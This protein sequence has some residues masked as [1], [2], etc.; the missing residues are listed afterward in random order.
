MNLITSKV[1]KEFNG[2]RGYI[3]CDTTLKTKDYQFKWSLT[4]QMI[5]E[6]KMFAEDFEK[7]FPKNFKRLSLIGRVLNHFN[8]KETNQKDRFVED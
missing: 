6:P 7:S 4:Y 5:P 2:G 3:W 1:S 8:I